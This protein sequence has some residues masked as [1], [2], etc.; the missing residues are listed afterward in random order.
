MASERIL[1]GG[2]WTTSIGSTTFT[3]MNPQSKE[4]LPF[5]FPVSPWSEVE[6]AIIAAKQAFEDLRSIA[7]EVRGAFLDRFAE[8]LEQ[9]KEELVE[10]AHTETALPKEPRLATVELPRTTHQLRQAAGAAREGSW[11]LPTIDTHANI[12]SLLRPIGPVA[13]FGPNN[14]PFAFNSVAGGDF[15]AAIAAGNPVIAKANTSHPSTT[16]WLAE[17]A[18]SAADEVGLP[19]AT[20]Q[21]LYR[22]SHE[23]GAKLVSHPWLGATGYTGARQAG[24]TLKRAADSAGK[25]IY[26]ELSSINPVVVLPEALAERGAQIAE[27]LQTSCLMGTGQFCTNPGMVLLIGG[28]HAEELVQSLAMRFHEAPVG[29]LLGTGVENSLASAIEKLTA[30]GAKVIAGGQRGGGKGCSYANT[31]LVASGAK[32]LAQPEKLQTEAFGNSTLFVIA[33]DLTELSKVLEALEGN[34]TGTIYSAKAGG[35]EEAYQLIEPILRGKVGRL[36]NDKMPTGVAVSP[37]M[38]HGGPFPATGHPGF[39]AV[40]I[41]ASLRRF[42]AL[43]CYDNVRP[44]RL[45]PE[46]RDTIATP[47]TWRLIDGAWRQG[48][49]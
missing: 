47:S 20:I 44:E 16:Q 5:Q 41:P 11:A 1:L 46:L 9:R 6:Q 48:S 31:I 42:A 30:A 35:D 8:R 19:P 7:A 49:I 33:S 37:A 27:E 10:R 2:K 17:E 36:L 43:H 14:F 40:G 21:L 12:R 23:D 26:L 38:N 28:P 45:P 34:L 18:K 15:A 3:S 29:T 39:T 22:L 4:T 13:V 24:L 25:P 32:F